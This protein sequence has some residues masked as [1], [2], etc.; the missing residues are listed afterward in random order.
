MRKTEVI[1]K[2]ATPIWTFVLQDHQK[3]NEEL[4][5]YIYFLKKENPSGVKK[6]NQLGWHSPNLDL[7]N[8]EIKIFFQTISPAIK[9]VSE[10][11]CWNL[12]NNQ[13]RVTNCWSIIN[14]KFAS[15]AGHIHAN[16]LISSA[17]YIRASEDSG[18]IIFDD[19]RPGATIKKGPYKSL[20]PWNEGNVSIQPKEG[21]LIMFPSYLVHHVQPNMSNQE[22]IILSFN[23]DVGFSK[24]D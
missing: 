14:K 13:V 18:K 16:S 24:N 21:L 20:S 2:F 17:Y 10:D 19:P 11:M 5:K 23:L 6:S 12:K 3:I 9:D 22:R 8:K 1:G 7:N 4:L 15:N